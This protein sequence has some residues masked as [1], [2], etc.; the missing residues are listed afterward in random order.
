MGNRNF[1]SAMTENWA[2]SLSYQKAYFLVVCY[3]TIFEEGKKK[4]KKYVSIFFFSKHTIFYVFY[5][6]GLYIFIHV[7]QGNQMLNTD[8]I[9]SKMRITFL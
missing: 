5:N 7:K 1:V 9:N 8:S 4:E 3:S 2:T 6:N